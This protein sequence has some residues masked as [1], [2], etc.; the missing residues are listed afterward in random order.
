MA[1][2]DNTAE[3]TPFI[4]KSLGIF[5]KALAK[6]ESGIPLNDL[7]KKVVSELKV[8]DVPEIETEVKD[9]PPE[10]ENEKELTVEKQEEVPPQEEE[11][12]PAETEPVAEEEP[13]TEPVT[14]EPKKARA[15][16]PVEQKKTETKKET[17]KEKSSS[18]YERYPTPV[19]LAEMGGHAVHTVYDEGKD[20]AKGMA[21]QGE[22]SG[23]ITD[24]V[25]RA[26]PHFD[27]RS[28]F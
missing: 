19:K 18:G 12:A 14:E 4:T 1:E 28:L 25:A 21:A 3:A 16:K 5:D 23:S 10:E 8:E 15:P 24:D 22:T 2:V 26:I 7:E 20:I 13:K 6:M 27:Y 17:K 11:P 9:L